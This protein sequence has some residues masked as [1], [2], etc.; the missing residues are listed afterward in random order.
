MKKSFVLLT[1]LLLT[2]FIVFSQGNNIINNKIISSLAVIKAN[3]VPVGY[4]FCVDKNL[5]ITTINAIGNYRNGQV[6]LQNG[7]H[8]NIEGY[9]SSDVDNDIVLLQIEY[10]SAISITMENKQPGAGQKTYLIN[11][12]EEG[13]YN[14]V[15]GTIKEVKNYDQFVL[16]TI[17]S[18]LQLTNSGL[19][20]FD[21]SG[22]ALGMSITPVLNEPGINFAIPIETIKKLIAD[23]A[24]LKKLYMLLPS[25][26]D[27]KKRKLS[28]MDRSKAVKELLDQGIEKYNTTDYKGAIDKYNVALR[29]SPN[30]ADVLV[31]RGQAKY[32]LMQYKDAMIDFSKAIDLQPEFAE[33]YD[34]RGLCKAEL[35]DKDGACNDWKLSF[36]KGYDP[37][38]KLLEKFCDLE[39][40]K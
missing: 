24:E 1:S 39:K 17:E 7:N 10:D 27:I 21:M 13:H 9:L 30:D 18:E 23:K 32:M 34:L 31:F 8:Y 35:G 19:P 5:V 33:A 29:L 38:F 40:M 2:S 14:L 4:G 15:D 22:N 26:E 6:L 36:E 25:F 12:G 20:V 16:Y 11:P 28:D 3:T 37:A